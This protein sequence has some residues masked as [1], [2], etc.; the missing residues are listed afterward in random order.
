ML[1]SYGFDLKTIKYFTIHWPAGQ[2][3]DGIKVRPARPTPDLG[4][5]RRPQ[6]LKTVRVIPPRADQTIIVRHN[7]S[8]LIDD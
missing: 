4:F 5:G 8:R 3:A 2:P 6:A 1:L 7:Y